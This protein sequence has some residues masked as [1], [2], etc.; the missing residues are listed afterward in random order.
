MLSNR[1]AQ[2]LFSK[3]CW[4]RDIEGIRQM[5]VD[6]PFLENPANDYI[7]RYNRELTKLNKLLASENMEE[8]DA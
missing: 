5:I 3:L 2:V 8:I 1:E 7:T 6:Y 4:L